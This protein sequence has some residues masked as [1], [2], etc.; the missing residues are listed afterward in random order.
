MA[1]I[2]VMLIFQIFKNFIRMQ[3][4]TKRLS[5]SQD[6]AD[7][8]MQRQAMANENNQDKNSHVQ[9][10]VAVLDDNEAKAIQD[11]HFNTNFVHI[12]NLESFIIIEQLAR[13]LRLYRLFC[14]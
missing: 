3:S 4:L 8:I 6:I 7:A 2:V 14:Q 10:Y 11:E 5:S 12:A 1:K 9:V 13:S